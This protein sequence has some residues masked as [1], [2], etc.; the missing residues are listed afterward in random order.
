M[1]AQLLVFFVVCCGA[2]LALLGSG[3]TVLQ[4]FEWKYT[5]IANECE[6]W[7]VAKKFAAIQVNI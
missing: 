7:L 2:T 3:D 5:D 4:F 1:R 6:D